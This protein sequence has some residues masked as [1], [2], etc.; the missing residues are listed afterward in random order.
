VNRIGRRTINHVYD[1][2]RGA[3][4]HSCRTMMMMPA[5]L[6]CAL[7]GHARTDRRDRKPAARPRRQKKEHGPAMGWGAL[8]RAPCRVHGPARIGYV[9]LTDKTGIRY[10]VPFRRPGVAVPSAGRVGSRTDE[11]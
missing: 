10:I 3:R 8:R 5:G 6:D 7:I 11:I 1:V 4:D 2:H 9:T